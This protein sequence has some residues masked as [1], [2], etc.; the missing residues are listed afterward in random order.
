[1]LF[2]A[3]FL[4][5]PAPDSGN[6]AIRDSRFC[7]TKVRGA[8]AIVLRFSRNLSWGNFQQDPGN[9]HGLLEEQSKLKT[10]FILARSTNVDETI[11]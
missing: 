11:H 7:A 9:G 8:I 2:A 10:I 4:A 3:E 5:I 1:M 6:H